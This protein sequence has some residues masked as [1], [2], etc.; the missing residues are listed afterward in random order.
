AARHARHRAAPPAE[1]EV[2]AGVDADAASAV[3]A[4]ALAAGGGWLAPAGAEALFR[5][6][7][8]PV[9]WSRVVAT[10]HAAG[11]AAGE[12]PGPFAVKAV[13][14]DV[15]RKADL[16]GVVLDVPG[17]TAAERAARAAGDALRALGHEPQGYVVQAMAPPGIEMLVGASSDVR[18]GP[19]VAC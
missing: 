1:P 12:A 16:G 8:V 18:F 17:P 10:P 2:P 3:V 4:R 9:L 5:A 14:P 15:P 19:T 13:A 7:G 6:Y 11:R